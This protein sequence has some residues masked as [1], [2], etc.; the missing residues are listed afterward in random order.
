MIY[1]DDRKPL[2]RWLQSQLRYAESEAEHL[3]AAPLHELSKVDR[4][5]RAGWPAPILVF[6]YVLLAKRAILDGWAGWF[7]AFQRLL[8]E[9]LLAL[10]I[11][12]RRLQKT[13]S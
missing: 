8:A 9:V 11:A 3:L 12:D 6:L 10:E 13:V 4:L 2:S 5:R 1:H 7:F